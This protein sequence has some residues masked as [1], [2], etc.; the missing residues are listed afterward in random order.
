MT[1]FNRINSNDELFKSRFN[2]RKGIDMDQY[3]KGYARLNDVIREVSVNRE[4]DLIDLDRLVPSSSD[5]IYDAV[6]LNENGSKL[7]ADIMINYWRD[8]LNYAD[9]TDN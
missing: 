6:H 8:K 5:Y 3:I 9:Y 2:N 1:Q 7:V 4:I